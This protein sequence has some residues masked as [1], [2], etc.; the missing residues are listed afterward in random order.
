MNREFLQLAHTLDPVK[1]TIGGWFWSEKLDGQRAFWDGGI[2]RGLAAADVPYANVEKHGRFKQEVFA[3]GLWS[4]YGQ[5]IRAPDWWLNK[6]PKNIPLDGELWM[7]RGSFQDAMSTVKHHEATNAWSN[8]RFMIFDLPPIQA[9]LADGRI[10]NTNF[11]KTFEGIQRWERINTDVNRFRP[12]MEFMSAQAFLRVNQ[13]ENDIV[14]ILHQE[15]LPLAQNA[16]L[17][18]IDKQCA[19]INQEGG[20]GIVL[21]KPESFWMPKRTL[22]LLKV[23]KLLDAEGEV[24]GCMSGRRT[25]KGSK[26]LGKMGSLIVKWNGKTFELSGFTDEE[27]MFE[28]DAMAAH[29]ALYPGQEMPEWVVVH[30][31]KRGSKVTFQYRELTKDGL[32]K[33]ARYYRKEEQ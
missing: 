17:E 23:K 8:V 22:T 19:K 7:G 32:P 6:L 16:A 27:R 1:H 4:R 11:R 21:R 18:V 12:F 33:E 2:S 14:Q 28:S 31:F 9:V 5:V 20:E 24:I 26:L 15:R 10:N 3:T 13:I 25:E 30:H 29:A